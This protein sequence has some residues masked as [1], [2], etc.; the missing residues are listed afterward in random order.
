M[1]R[2]EDVLNC[3]V[4]M[5]ARAADLIGSALWRTY[6]YVGYGYVGDGGRRVRILHSSPPHDADSPTI[7]DRGV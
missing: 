1:V 3:F 7:L 4:Q 5:K 6:G 2:V